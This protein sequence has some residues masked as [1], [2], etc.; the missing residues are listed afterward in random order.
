MLELEPIT[1]DTTSERQQTA[2][3]VRKM[4]ASHRAAK[5]KRSGKQLKQDHSFVQIPE[6]T[7]DRI[8]L[9]TGRNKY[10]VIVAMAWLSMFWDGWKSKDKRRRKKGRLP[11][12]EAMIT[13]RMM[14]DLFGYSE[15]TF[16]LA[17]RD[18]LDIGMTSIARKHKYTGKNGENLGRA[19]KCHW[20]DCTAGKQRI[21]LYWGLLVSDIFLSLDI[22]SQAILIL[23]HADHNRKHNHVVINNSRLVAMGVSKRIINRHVDLLRHAGLLI[24]VGDGYKFAWLQEGGRYENG[25]EEN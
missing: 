15:N 13:R 22:T 12:K 25:W 14:A 9:K 2:N 19:Y 8:C 3:R 1:M 6:E 18:L 11:R 21:W 24:F 16:G 17:L 7:L 23:I 5:P 10:R 4:L 20:M